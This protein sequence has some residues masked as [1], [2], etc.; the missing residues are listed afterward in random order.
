MSTPESP[1]SASVAPHRS[2]VQAPHRRRSWR[3]WTVIAIGAMLAL[4]YLFSLAAY[5]EAGQGQ[6]ETGPDP[7]SQGADGVNFS[8][9]MIAIDPA[10]HQMTL[11]MLINPQGSFLDANNGSFAKSLRITVRFQTSGQVTRDI[12]AGTAV[13]GLTDLNMF[14]DGNPNTYPFDQYNFGFAAPDNAA[15]PSNIKLTEPAT[16]VAVTELGPENVPLPTRIPIGVYPSGGLQGWTESW[17]Y[18]VSD[19]PYGQITAGDTLL[20]QLTVKHGSGVLSFVLVVLTLM[21]VTAILAGLVARSVARKQRPIEA[22]MASWFA[23]LLFAF[24]PLRTNLPD[25]P[26]IGAWIDVAVFFWVEL[27]LLIAMV[28]FIGSWLRFRSPPDD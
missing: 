10:N 15:D 13:G 25:A 8:F 18:S 4:V 5:A 1:N 20:L 27:A 17:N 23:V 24:V 26:S 9:D 22:A 28:V 19:R 14:V 3:Q 21:V 16:L 11:R 6:V 2:D 12:P 7:I